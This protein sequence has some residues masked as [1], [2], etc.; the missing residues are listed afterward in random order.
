M[1]YLFAFQSNLGSCYFQHEMKKILQGLKAHIYLD[2]MC[3]T[4]KNDEE[5]L[6][7]MNEVFNKLQETGIKL[8]PEKCELMNE[9]V[10]Y[11]GHCTDKHGLLNSSLLVHFDNIKEIVFTCD[12]SPYG[13]G[14]VLSHKMPESD[15][16]TAFTS[17]SLSKVEKNYSHI[18]KEAMALVFGATKFR[19]YLLGCTFTLLT[20]VSCF[21]R[22][23]LPLQ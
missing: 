18:E 19:N 15:H 10:E 16:P 23:N 2:D 7:N 17:H 4:G 21:Q 9:L 5:H 8:H 6:Q 11:F 1:L 3:I 20:L 14:A 13:F 22:T 12:T